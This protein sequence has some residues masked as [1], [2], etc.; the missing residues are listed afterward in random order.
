MGAPQLHF[1][2]YSRR[3]AGAGT[4]L[5]IGKGRRLVSLQLQLVVTPTSPRDGGPPPPAAAP[6]D[7]ASAPLAVM[8]PADVCGLA[9]NQIVRRM[10]RAGDESMEPNY[11]AGIEFAHPDLPWMF[12]LGSSMDGT[13]QPW[14][15]LVALPVGSSS[16]ITYLPNSRCPV[17]TLP[18]AESVPPPSDAWAYAHVQVY[19]ASDGHQAQDWVRAP[20][21]HTAAVR[22]RVLCPTRLAP[23]T[24]YIAAVVPTYEIGRLAG[25]GLDPQVEA[26]GDTAW[27]PAAGLQL[28]VYDSWTFRTGPMG[29]FEQLARRLHRTDP[30]VMG[31]L[32]SR[33][34][35][36]EP[37]GSMLPEDAFPEGF[38]GA[39]EPGVFDVPTA[40]IRIDDSDEAGGTGGVGPLAPDFSGGG[41]RAVVLH[42]M[43]K[44]LLNPV[45]QDGDE[46]PIVGPPLYGQ[47]PARVRD[48]DGQP[49]S[50]TLANV[51]SDVGSRQGWIEQ[52]NADPFHRMA[53]GLGAAIVQRDQEE[54]MRDAWEQLA[55]L[56]RANRRIRWSSLHMAAATFLHRRVADADS[57][58]QLRFLSPALGRLRSAAGQSFYGRI[59]ASVVSPEVLTTAFAHQSRAARQAARRS[60]EVSG[61]LGAIVT[62]PATGAVAADAVEVLQNR[63]ELFQPGRFSAKSVGPEFLE[64]VAREPQFAERFQAVL[65]MDGPA[66]LTRIN[67]LP[68]VLGK[69]AA[70][71]V[72]VEAARPVV[73][74]P[75]EGPVDRPQGG[76]GRPIGGIGRSADVN[77]E[78]PWSRGKL[79]PL[80]RPAAGLAAR[81]G[82]TSADTHRLESTAAVNVSL[83]TVAQAGELQNPQLL[84]QR[85]QLSESRLTWSAALAGAV[86]GAGVVGAA[87]R[88]GP[89]G[90]SVVALRDAAAE[91]LGTQK[92]QGS[93]LETATREGHGRTLIENVV[94]DWAFVTP[95][96]AAATF[97]TGDA[98]TS[99][100]GQQLVQA[101]E[102]AVTYS[103]MLAWAA[104]FDFSLV[105]KRQDYAFSQAMAAPNFPKP[106]VERL[107]KVSEK[108]VLGGADK[109]APNSVC[110]LE[111]NWRFVESLLAGANHEMA[112]EML[113]RRYPTDLRG[114]P[115]RRFWGG[116]SDDVAAMD[117]WRGPLGVHPSRAPG[118]TGG[119]RADVTLLLLK[120]DLLR[121]YPHTE[122]TAVQGT[123]GPDNT[124]TPTGARGD[125]IFRG[126]LSPDIS[127]VGLG[128][129]PHTLKTVGPGNPPARW[130]IQLLEPPSEPRF[131]LDENP[132]AAPGSNRPPVGVDPADPSGLSIT[133]GWSWQ[134]LNPPAADAGAT[135]HLSPQQCVSENAAFA[136]HS[137]IT[138]QRLFMKPFR[139]LMLGTDYI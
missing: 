32:G 45:A 54:L 44:H 93:W 98:W 130:Y 34:V 126:Q 40:I 134:G 55:E 108:W 47:W 118:A 21:G 37:R 133:D 92:L 26:N 122:I 38:G 127:Y 30:D 77:R 109:L 49:D 100:A 58:S 39:A 17:L 123:E 79:D 106:A 128:I 91:L 42:A 64:K 20:D 84:S 114:S 103:K 7:V 1:L 24:N 15:M 121:R 102:P 66:Y 28:P 80:V 11:L 4:G 115:F 104:E 67:T 119:K 69:L 18:N 5:G 65:G 90:T 105:A 113:W 111:V 53:A 81:A 139:L 35:V 95:V 99:A 135:L 124:F 125:E 56:E 74:E 6:A 82:W 120:G 23:E 71:A 87:E 25:L 131:G 132:S 41:G 33:A 88:L 2:P 10:P 43:L 27:V 75:V 136:G 138:A 61:N 86:S 94:A 96:T 129:T 62:V 78:L 85:L 31:Q 14:I 63:A 51:D 137:A 68:D 60:A 13:V 48:I 29:D 36:I 112:R 116:A 72:T 57:A 89:A 101:M 16:P 52:L 117:S 19:G 50:A 73:R 3:G 76:A 107:K 83:L 97:P 8:G 59:D 12:A 110:L 9:D 22:S 46:D 70:M